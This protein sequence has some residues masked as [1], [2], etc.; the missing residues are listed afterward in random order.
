MK[1][2]SIADWIW[3]LIS[4]MGANISHNSYIFITITSLYLTIAIYKLVIVSLHLTILT[5]FLNFDFTSHN[6]DIF[7]QNSEFASHN[8]DFFLKILV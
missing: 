6:S 1:T 2:G 7:P 8:S 4:H 3:T 5:F